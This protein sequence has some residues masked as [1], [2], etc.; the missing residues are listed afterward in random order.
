MLRNPAR[1]VTICSSDQLCS[2]V[3]D[4]DF[5]VDVDQVESGRVPGTAVNYL[6][7]GLL[8]RTSGAILHNSKLRVT[9]FLTD[10]E[11]R[12]IIDWIVQN[13]GHP[14]PFNFPNAARIVGVQVQQEQPAL[15]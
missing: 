4:M 1:R 6:A 3:L 14:F 15:V 7:S 11:A 9:V 10:D 12:N 2:G 8:Q 5:T 13:A